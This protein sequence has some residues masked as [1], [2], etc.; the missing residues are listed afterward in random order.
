MNAE[1]SCGVYS[2]SPMRTV[3][4]VPIRRLIE[5]TVRSG[6]NSH[7]LR[8]G[9]PTSNR[10]SAS[11]PTTDGRIASPSSQRTST[12]PLRITATSLL[13]VPKSIPSMV[14]MQGSGLGIK[15]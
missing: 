12:L 15:N 6:A 14:S 13:V 11:L 5:R 3:S 2:R 9:A 1:I 10:P 8:A 4:A 7:W